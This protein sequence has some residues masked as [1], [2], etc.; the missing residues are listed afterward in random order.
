M[1]VNVLIVVRVP[2]VAK[3]RINHMVVEVFSGRPDGR[4][5]SG[6]CISLMEGGKPDLGG[7]G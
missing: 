6:Q 4:V 3:L 2:L 7:E 5:F 1:A